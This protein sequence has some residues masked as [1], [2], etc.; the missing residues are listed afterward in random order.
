MVIQCDRL[1]AFLKYMHCLSKI[2]YEEVIYHHRICT[3]S[4]SISL[5]FLSE[6]YSIEVGKQIFTVCITDTWSCMKNA[7]C[8]SNLQ[9]HIH[10]LNTKEVYEFNKGTNG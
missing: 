8:T 7:D 6:M 10:K 4:Q 1:I 5:V 9:N 2:L 3:A